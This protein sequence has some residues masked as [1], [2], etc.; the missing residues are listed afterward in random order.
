MQ[1]VGKGVGMVLRYIGYKVL[2][3]IWRVVVRD[4][5]CGDGV[6]MVWGIWGEGS[7]KSVM[8]VK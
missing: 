4:D 6:G 7:D 2:K 5:D 3:H 8:M 1:H